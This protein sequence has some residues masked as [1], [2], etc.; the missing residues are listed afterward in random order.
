MK[1]AQ[2]THRF[3]VQNFMKNFTEFFECWSLLRAILPAKL[4]DVIPN[5]REIECSLEINALLC[6]INVAL[7]SCT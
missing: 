2:I 4:H 7:K 3:G 5:K 1:K 6:K